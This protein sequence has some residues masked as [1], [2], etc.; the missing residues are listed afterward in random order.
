[1]L[2]Y[3]P[4][5]EIA[6][7]R[8]DAFWAN[9]L[10]DRPL[11]SITYLKEDAE[12]L[13][14]P[15]Y[16]S[17]EDYWLDIEFR[18]EEDAQY[19]KNLVFYA[20]AMPVVFPNLGPGIFSAWSGCPY[21]FG[22]DTAWTNP[23]IVDWEQDYFRAVL[24][25]SHPMFKKTEEYTRFLIE[26][27][28]GKFI[29]GLTDFHPGGDHLAALRGS[30]NLALD[31]LENPDFVKQKL[32]DSYLEYF[33]VFDYFCDMIKNAGMPITSWLPLVHDDRMYVPSND[34]SCMI[35]TAMFREFFL[36]DLVNECRYYKNNIYHLDGPGA[37]HHLD[38][39]LEINEINAVQWV[40]GAGHD[41]PKRWLHVYKRILSAGKSVQILN[42]KPQDLPFL[43]ENL[44]PKG[45]WLY[46]TGIEDKYSADEVMKLV[47][48]WV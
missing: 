18:A 31:L 21:T 28:K 48:K 41:D 12:W 47:N 26:Y 19:M 30:D 34:F 16:K 7:R 3:K 11:V 4:E 43:M 33:K 23:C 39:L 10:I 38:T 1:M 15:E 8:M 37:L 27:G 14:R 25:M 35:S 46:M 17:H 2:E 36:D 13:T 45:V 24:D 29:V 20:D 44:P 9:E 40:P 22:Q 6:K 42:V 5:Y 32:T